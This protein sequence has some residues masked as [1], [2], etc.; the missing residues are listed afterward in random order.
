EVV[1]FGADAT[2][3]APE[4]A[5]VYFYEWYQSGEGAFRIYS[6]VDRV[7]T[8]E[9]LREGEVHL[10]YLAYGENGRPALRGQRTVNIVR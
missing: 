10:E 6:S 2:Y 8:F 9:A 4:D 7:V 1:L 5:R 3:K